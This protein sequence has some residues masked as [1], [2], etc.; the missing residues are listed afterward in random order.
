MANM[1]YQII[2]HIFFLFCITIFIEI[3]TANLWYSRFLGY[4]KIETKRWY[5]LRPGV[6]GRCEGLDTRGIWWMWRPSASHPPK[7]LVSRPPHPP[8]LLVSM[9]P[10]FVSIL[11]PQKTWNH[12]FAVQVS[13]K[14]S[15]KKKKCEVSF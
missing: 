7:P 3:W 11:K 10:P 15:C 1:K 12:I 4:S 5:S 8:K 6:F 14:S 9:K 13:L 2:P